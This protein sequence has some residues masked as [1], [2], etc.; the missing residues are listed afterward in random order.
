MPAQEPFDHDIK[1]KKLGQVIR[2]QVADQAAREQKV[3]EEA[4]NKKNREILNQLMS[5]SDQPPMTVCH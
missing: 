2:C 1:G 3:T 5:S 4:R